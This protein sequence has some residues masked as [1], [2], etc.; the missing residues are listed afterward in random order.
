MSPEIFNHYKIGLPDIDAA[1]W[2]ILAKLN[3]A[4]G[5]SDLGQL[6][7]AVTA[8]AEAI[9]ML[10]IEINEEEIKMKVSNFPYRQNHVLAHAKLLSGLRNAHIQIQ[11]GFRFMSVRYT[12]GLWQR[13]FLE[14]MDQYDIQWGEFAQ[15][16]N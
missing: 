4:K 7:F 5:F 6:P 11:N 15:R 12:L 1:H 8:V 3:D 14:H 2:D 13:S 9:E 16:N 10:I